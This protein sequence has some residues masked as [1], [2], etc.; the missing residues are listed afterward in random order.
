MGDRFFS[1]YIQNKYVELSM[2]LQIEAPGIMK[3]AFYYQFI[4]DYSLI[5]DS[6]SKI[7]FSDL[8]E[9]EKVAFLHNTE[10]IKAFV[11]IAVSIPA[12]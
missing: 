3:Q 1:L 7:I 9:D 2:Q 5:G 11:F 4:S 8:E 12:P 10:M 6:Y